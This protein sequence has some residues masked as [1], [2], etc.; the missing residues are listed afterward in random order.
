MSFQ[1]TAD[2]ANNI[3]E[4]EGLR[5]ALLRITRLDHEKC[6]IQLDSMLV[7]KQ[8]N[9][10]WRCL[11]EHLKTR[12]SECHSM[13]N[14][15]SARRRDVKIVHIYREYNDHADRLANQGADGVTQYHGW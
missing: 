3:T 8:I 10:L 13:L 5:Q 6:I 7:C 2:N 1:M 15:L 14:D 11:A 12:W 4:Y 9:G